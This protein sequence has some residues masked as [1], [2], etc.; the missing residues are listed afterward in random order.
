[1]VAA[2]AAGKALNAAGLASRAEAVAGSFFDPLPPGAGGYLLSAILHNW[3]DDAACAILRR[4]EEAAGTAAAVFV[5]EKI[6]AGG[7]SLPAL[8]DLILLV[9]FARKEPGRT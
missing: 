3:T 7:R 1:M 8:I 9:H 2:E 4:C 6:G 5:V